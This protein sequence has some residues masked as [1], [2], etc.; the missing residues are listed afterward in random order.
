MSPLS[1]PVLVGAA[2]VSSPALWAAFV[3]GS[4][5]PETALVRY[6]I[7]AGLCWAAFAFFSMLVGPPPR[8]VPAEVPAEDGATE[9]EPVT[10]QAA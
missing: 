9:S 10:E 8:P 1:S 7:C 6:L 2:L 4:T 5:S 3:E